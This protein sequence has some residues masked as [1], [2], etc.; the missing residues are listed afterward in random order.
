M[1]GKRS[2]A[3]LATGIGI[4]L[5]LFAAGSFGTTRALPT[6]QPGVDSFVATPAARSGATLAELI[7]SLQT[8]LQTVPGD[9][10]GWATLGIAYV[11]QAK[12]TV[13][14]TLYPRADGALA[15][16][17][18][19]NQADNYLAYAGLSALSSARH[20]F[21][22]ARTFAQRGIA[23]NA[24]NALLYGALSDAEL[25]LG[26]YDAALQ[27]VQRMV[28][29]SPDTAS[30]SRA[31]YTWELRG[32]INEA[33]RLM[34][35]ALDDAP[36]AADRA[37]ALVQLGGLAGD[38]GDPNTAL[39]HYVAALAASPSD[40]SA[41]IGKA[42]SEAAL[43]QTQ[44]A[45][46]DYGSAVTRAPEPGYIVEYARLLESVGQTEQ[47][48][49]QY[50]VLAATQR[51]F[52]QNGVEP[53]ATTTLV[54]I[55]RGDV[56]KALGDAERAVARRPFMDMHDAHAWALHA[57]GRHQEALDA[58]NRA[59][60]FGTRKALFEF[61]AGMISLSLGDTVEARTRLRSA[62]A[63][64]PAFDPLSAKVARDTLASLELAA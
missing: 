14:P 63:I 22:E 39:S 18:E 40:V 57:T 60:A 55:D 20:D 8:R 26:N 50:K 3:I 33:R 44:T 46:S 4:G 7:A 52:A 17:L 19:I 1:R 27:A 16:S 59:R 23:I 15:R 43:G 56:A 41:L 32:N 25:Q 54:D 38:Q 10:V 37:F 28:D 36:T 11:Q 12:T 47:A 34:Q 5:T 64:D 29:L 45:L 21:T 48:S 61:H 9:H 2:W 6:T 24:F 51:L 53:D 49:E 62:V 58:I 31:S 30:L 13:D 35:R 42:R